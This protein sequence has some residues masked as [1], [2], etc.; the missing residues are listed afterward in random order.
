MEMEG[1]DGAERDQLAIA[2]LKRHK[3]LKPGDFVLVSRGYH[4]DIGGSTDT[5]RIVEVE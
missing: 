4:Q 1:L 5:L 3:L 2:D